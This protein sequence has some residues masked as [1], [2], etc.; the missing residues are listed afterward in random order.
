MVSKDFN[1]IVEQQ[2][3][4]IRSVL[5]KK[6]DEYNLD[7]DRLSVFKHAAALSQETPEQALFGFWLKHI[8][9]ITDM[10][11]SGETYPE[12]LWDEKITDCMN[13]CL[14]LRGLLVDTGR[15]DTTKAE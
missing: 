5:I 4:R 13:Y 2:L 11:N 1:N 14:L 10:I 7:S 6:A 15:I 8:I 9:S 12:A 3:A